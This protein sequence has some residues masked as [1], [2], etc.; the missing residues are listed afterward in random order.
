MSHSLA[1]E[2]AR[3]A[4]WFDYRAI[5]LLAGAALIGVAALW[6]AS[7]GETAVAAL[8]AELASKQHA[9]QSAVAARAQ[10]G[11]LSPERAR[12]INDAIRRLNLPWADILV[13]LNK[14]STGRVALLAQE[15]DPSTGI[16][17]LLAEAKSVEAMLEYQRRLEALFP[18]AVLTRHE[19]MA[20]EPGTPVRFSIET[21][22]GGP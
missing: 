20:K 1:I 22:W 7:A 16:I 18:E 2:F 5:A 17:K 19:V 9:Q 14:A 6:Q 21:R 15:P 12:A 11:A 10:A 4:W 8:H 3:R 13:T